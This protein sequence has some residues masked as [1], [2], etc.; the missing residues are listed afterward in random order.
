[1]SRNILVGLVDLVYF[2]D[3]VGIVGLVDIVGDTWKRGKGCFLCS[4]IRASE[5]PL[6]FI[7]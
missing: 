2:V 7:T 6:R 3:L 4:G 1:M 5:S